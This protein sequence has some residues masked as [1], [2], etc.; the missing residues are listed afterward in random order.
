M[1][2]PKIRMPRK[3]SGV[4]ADLKESLKQAA[5]WARGERVLP[6]RTVRRPAG[7]APR[8]APR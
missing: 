3:P 8:K 5:E 2:K 6:V 1:L 7:P 4:A